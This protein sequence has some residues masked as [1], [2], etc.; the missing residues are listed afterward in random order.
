MNEF[1]KIV[2]DDGGLLKEAIKT[3]D[4]QEV[5]EIVN[6]VCSVFNYDSRKEGLETNLA[7]NEEEKAKEELQTRKEVSLFLLPKL[8]RYL[9]NEF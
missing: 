8:K 1:R 9:Y 2:S 4:L 7:E 5:V 6:S 3:G